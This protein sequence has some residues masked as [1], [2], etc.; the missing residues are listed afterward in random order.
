MFALVTLLFSIATSYP[1]G[2]TPFLGDTPLASTSF[3]PSPTDPSMAFSGVRSIVVWREGT[4]IKSGEWKGT[5][6]DAAAITILREGVGSHPILAATDRAAFA[7]WLVDGVMEGVLLAPNGK[8]VAPPAQFGS[9]VKQFAIAASRD[10]FLVVWSDDS[11][12]LYSTLIGSGGNVVAPPLPISTAMPAAVGRISVT[13][14]GTDFLVAWDGLQE[15]TGGIFTTIVPAFSALASLTPQWLSKSGVSP[16]VGWNGRDYFVV[17]DA[18][19]ALVGKHVATNG[20]ASAGEPIRIHIGEAHVPQVVWDGA[21][22]VLG[23]IEI[24]HA[25]Q[26]SFPGLFTFRLTEYGT[27]SEWLPCSINAGGG[28]FELAARN[29][30][31]LLAYSASSIF[32]NEATLGPVSNLPRRRARS[33]G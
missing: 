3:A 30:H 21:G 20:T 14:D 32:M 16:S 1:P 17:W 25:R 6:L 4:T 10:A 27:V 28:Q 31:A 26:Y 8:P 22:Y 11:N 9:S 24:F 29:G 13:S 18:I 5:T 7:A 2:V 15:H 23:T 12:V 33:G 19:G